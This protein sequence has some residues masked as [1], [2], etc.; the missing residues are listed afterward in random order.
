MTDRGQA[1]RRPPRGLMPRRARRRWVV[2][3]GVAACWAVL[4]GITGSLTAATL[5]LVLIAAFG[6][7]LV[8]GLRTLGITLDHPWVQQLRSRPWRDGQEVLRLALRHLPDVFVITPGGT[9]LA[10]NSVELWLNPRD[11][12]SLSELMDPGLVNAS[13]AEVYQEEVAAHGA[14]FARPGLA[15][16]RVV[17]DPSVLPGRYRLRQARPVDTE[18]PYQPGGA[19]RPEPLAASAPGSALPAQAATPPQAA[20]AAAGPWPSARDGWT[21]GDEAAA[22]VIPGLPTVAERG[23]VPVLRLVTGDCVAQTQVSGARAGRGDVELALPE[24]LTV[25]REHARFTY[26][27][28]HWWVENLGRNGLTLNGVPLEGQRPVRDGDTIRWGAAADALVSRVRIS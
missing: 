24:V 28:G 9:L 12:R 4:L 3:A 18:V 7:L 22:T 19:A 8:I 1:S 17:S 6:V 21:Y 27:D 25:S 10:P 13:A 14:R 26:A 20:Q 16:V 11:V 15:E 5:L 23:P 2:A